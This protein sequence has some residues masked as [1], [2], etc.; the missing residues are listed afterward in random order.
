MAAPFAT[1]SDAAWADRF[2]E[3][4]PEARRLWEQLVEAAGH[5]GPIQV[6]ATKS[7]GALLGRTRFAWCPQAHKVGTLFLRFHFPA[8]VDLPHA[9]NDPMPDGRTS[10]RLRVTEADA[11]TL[12]LLKQAYQFDMG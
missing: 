12:A 5:W 6:V 2:F 3:G 1:P 10:V 7:R 4:Y 8:P 11:G 9:R